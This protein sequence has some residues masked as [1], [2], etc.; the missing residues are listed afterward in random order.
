MCVLVK[1]RSL[2]ISLGK[3]K[4]QSVENTLVGH[5]SSVVVLRRSDIMSHGTAAAPF[6][7]RPGLQQEELDI[8]GHKSNEE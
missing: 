5:L 8:S 2:I 7:A 3:C 6:T 4:S 1:T